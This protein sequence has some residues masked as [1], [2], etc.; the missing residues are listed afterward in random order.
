V[1]KSID[2]ARFLRDHWQK[3]PW[4]EASAL[5]ARLPELD[6]DELAWLATQPD[7]ESR[8]ILTVRNG[9]DAGYRVE[10]GPFDEQRLGALPARD[11]TLLV[12]D[13]DKQLPD[14]RAWTD[15]VGFIPGW[16][17]DDLMVSLAAPGGSVGPHRDNYD[18][19]LCQGAGVREWRIGD[20]Q[21]A[22]A[23]ASSDALSLLEP[24]AAT[25]IFDAGPGDVLYLPPGVPHWGIAQSLCTTWSI[26]FRA[27]TKRGLRLTAEGLVPECR[28]DREPDPLEQERFYQDPD[29]EPAEADDGRIADATL[30]RLRQQSLLEADCSD[31]QLATILGITVTDPKAWLDPEPVSATVAARL[32]SQPADRDVHGMALLAWFAGGDRLLVFANGRRFATPRDYE[33]LLRQLCRERRCTAAV[34]QRVCSRKNGRALFEWLTTSGVFQVDECHE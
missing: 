17:I 10:N 9:D 25:E 14:F 18:V 15:A 32:C 34:Q 31:E 3:K 8:L 5:P 12:Q 22:V 30:R 1:L 33:P 27:P 16:R 26:G 29:L 2:P 4:F 19:F 20:S 21:A 13:V 24:F 6:A 23:D 11:W 7:V 28:Q